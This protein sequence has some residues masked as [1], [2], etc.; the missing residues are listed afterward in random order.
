MMGSL[1]VAVN[2][3]EVWVYVVKL[4]DGLRVRFDIDDWQRLNLGHGHRIPV[5]VPGKADVWLFVTNVT[6]LPPVVWVTMTRRVRA[7]G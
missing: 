6:E 3:A 1:Q 5:R 4:Y 2:G 7:A